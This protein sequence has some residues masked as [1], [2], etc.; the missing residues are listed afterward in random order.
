MDALCSNRWRKSSQ[1]DGQFSYTQCYIAERKTVYVESLLMM[2]EQSVFSLT[3][4]SYQPW[5]GN[6]PAH[7]GHYL[8][9][10]CWTVSSGF[11]PCV[12]GGLAGTWMFSYRQVVTHTERLATGHQEN[13]P[14]FL[15]VVWFSS[16]KVP[17]HTQ[18]S[19]ILDQKCWTIQSRFGT[20]WFYIFPTLNEHLSQHCSTT[21]EDIKHAT[22][23]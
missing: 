7:P 9:A 6:T 5:S 11:I 4:V 18:H 1:T 3:P 15:A 13:V 12:T 16:M 21:N 8:L 17:D 22:I 10:K 23:T 20:H 14:V 2:R 19:K